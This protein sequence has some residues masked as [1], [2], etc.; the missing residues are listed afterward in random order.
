MTTRREFTRKQRAQIVHRATNE[1]G[2]VACEGCGLVLGKKPYEIDHI[3]AEELVI[4]KSRPLTIE[5]GELLGKEC[6]HRGADGKTNRDV[7]VIA[8]AKRVEAKHYGI[9]KRSTL[10]GRGFSKAPPQRRATGEIDKWYGW[11]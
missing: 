9:R 8:K 7:K 6:C 11:K 2:H 10:Q 1:N 3:I 5:D 4:D